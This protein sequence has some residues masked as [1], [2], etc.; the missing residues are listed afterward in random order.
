MGNEGGIQPQLSGEQELKEP[1]DGLFLGSKETER[2]REEKL[3]LWRCP[4]VGENLRETWV[5]NSAICPPSQAK[6]GLSCVACSA[7]ARGDWC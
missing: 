6:E 3:A 7:R 4:M 5:V 1:S 2:K